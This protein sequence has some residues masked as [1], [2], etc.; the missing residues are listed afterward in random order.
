LVLFIVSMIP[1]SGTYTAE[2]FMN[3]FLIFAFCIAPAL[4]LCGLGLA[5]AGMFIKSSKKFF[6]VIGLILNAVPLLAVLVVWIF[7]FWVLWALIASGGGWH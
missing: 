6:P 2:R 7:L 1:K 3:I 5:I 4:Y